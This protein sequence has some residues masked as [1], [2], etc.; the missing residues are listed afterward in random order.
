MEKIKAI[1]CIKDNIVNIQDLTYEEVSS[2]SWEDVIINCFKVSPSKMYD[3]EINTISLKDNYY[4]R[5]KNELI[6]LT[7]L[8]DLNN[9]PK[10][11]D[12]LFYIKDEHNQI[13]VINGYSMHQKY[14]GILDNSNI[15][16]PKF[17]TGLEKE[18][19]I[20]LTPIIEDCIEIFI[21]GFLSK[22]IN[23][24]F[25]YIDLN[26]LSNFINNGEINKEDLCKNPINLITIGKIENNI[27]SYF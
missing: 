3:K 6:P 5:L 19:Y 26:T 16:K 1:L 27:I 13:F 2:K 20:K 18:D 10:L 24:N 11:V 15:I 23:C 9:L 22:K 7:S 12:K 21:N 8:S 14:I 17:I 4:I 25:G